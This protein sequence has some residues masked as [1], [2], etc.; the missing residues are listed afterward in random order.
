[1]TEYQIFGVVGIVSLLMIINYIHHV[2]LVRMIKL[3]IVVVIKTQVNVNKKL[4]KYGNQNMMINVTLRMN[5]GLTNG[6][7]QIVLAKI[8]NIIR[9]AILNLL[10]LI[11]IY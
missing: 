1:M 6:V 9:T 2:T 10:N 5:Q 4:L 3:D 8:I 11:I 7:N